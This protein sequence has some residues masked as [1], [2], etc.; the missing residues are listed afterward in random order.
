MKEKKSFKKNVLVVG[1]GRSGIGAAKL[2]NAEGHKVIVFEKADGPTFNDLAQ[3]LC[4][5]GIMVELGKPL[6]PLSFEPWLEN[7]DF[8]VISPGIPW[9]H[10]TLN[11]L[12]KSIKLQNKSL[13]NSMLLCWRS[14][15]SLPL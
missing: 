11:E 3:Q 10:P 2:L 12:R 6:E 14:S 5:E 13:F 9:D 7:L 4:N 1:L 15:F 8:V